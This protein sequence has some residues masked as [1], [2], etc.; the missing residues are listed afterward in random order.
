MLPLHGFR[1]VL[2]FAL[3]LI[4]VIISGSSCSPN[5]S[6]ITSSISRTS[7]LFIYAASSF[8]PIINEINQRYQLRYPQRHIHVTLTGSH[9]A[10]L[11]LE[12]GAPPGVFISASPRHIDALE[13]LGKVEVQ[14]TIARN[15]LVLLTREALNITSL[16]QI[17][18]AQ[19]WG[20]GH[21]RV[22][23]GQ[24]AESLL[25]ALYLKGR[26]LI[27]RVTPHLVTRA[28]SARA[29]RGR[30]QREELDAVILY[31]TDLPALPTWRVVPLP[32]KLTARHQARYVIALTRHQTQDHASSAAHDWLK[33]ITH[34]QGSATMK[35][36]GFIPEVHA[37]SPHEHR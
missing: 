21:A 6:K 18:R 31:Q 36:L 14:Q 11:Q 37:S 5:E 30:A 4:G 10:R 23:I 25:R 22:P 3:S 19:R 33:L 16:N 20:L 29:L 12:R 15:Q 27:E 13:R 24:L 35:R 26:P 7:A 28:L 32:E 34:P 17:D 2:G 8:E 1:S 9:T